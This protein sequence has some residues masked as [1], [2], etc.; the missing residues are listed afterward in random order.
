MV[1]RSPRYPNADLEDAVLQISK[2]FSSDRRNPIDRLVAAK[3]MGYSSLNGSADKALAAL[4]QYGLLEKVAKGEVCVSQVA[5]DIL[6]PEAKNDRSDAISRAAY[7][8]RVFAAIRERFPDGHFSDESLKSFLIRECNSFD[9]QDLQQKPP[10]FKA[11][12]GK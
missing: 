8:P 3:H 11:R 9:Y 5:V 6:H 2:V 4:M 12:R 1:D 10:F 7:S